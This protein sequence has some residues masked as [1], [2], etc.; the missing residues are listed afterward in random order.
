[1]RDGTDVAEGWTC[2]HAGCTAVRVQWNTFYVVKK[3]SG[4]RYG[5][6]TRLHHRCSVENKVVSDSQKRVDADACVNHKRID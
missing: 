6:Y 5:P 1:M 3:A 4:V 2:V